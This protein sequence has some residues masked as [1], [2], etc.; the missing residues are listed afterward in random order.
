MI[1]PER[2]FAQARKLFCASSLRIFASILVLHGS[3]TIADGE[4]AADGVEVED[5]VGVAIGVGVVEGV[6]LL[7]G[8]A[9]LMA[10]PLFQIGLLPFLIHV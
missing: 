2:C 8:A 5:G 10:T 9:D 4:G 6:G 7:A 1:E 3:K